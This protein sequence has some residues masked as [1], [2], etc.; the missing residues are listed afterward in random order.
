MLL[1]GW[2]GWLWGQQLEAEEPACSIQKSGPVSLQP[3]SSGAFL[4]TSAV[5][6][7]FLGVGQKSM[8]PQCSVEFLG[9]FLPPSTFPTQQWAP[10]ARRDDRSI[11]MPCPCLAAHLS[12]LS[13]PS[14]TR[15]PRMADLSIT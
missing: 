12:P 1:A 6:W 15:T 3:T 4:G 5:T 8:I 2:R 11:T 13:G 14:G 7:A 9:V 10:G